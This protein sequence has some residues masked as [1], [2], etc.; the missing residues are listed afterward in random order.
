MHGI[1]EIGK[2]ANIWI[3]W[4]AEAGC[5]LWQILPLGPTGYGDSPYQ[6]FSSFAGNTLLIDLDQLV[7][8]GLLS[9]QDF[10]P[11]PEFSTHHV[12]YTLVMDYKERLLTLA[13]ERFRQGA[14]DHLKDDYE[15]F[16]SEK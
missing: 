13:A 4:L 3:D 16:C 2:A 15:S 14:A 11:R 10:D 6:S 8:E 7:E 1:G 9:I 12:D 5:S